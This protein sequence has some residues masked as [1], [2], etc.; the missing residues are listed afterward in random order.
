MKCLYDTRYH[1]SALLMMCSMVSVNSANYYCYL[2]VYVVSY[3][4]SFLPSL[5]G[6]CDDHRACCISLG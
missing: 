4:V 5:P 1:I 3:K 6:F 2:L